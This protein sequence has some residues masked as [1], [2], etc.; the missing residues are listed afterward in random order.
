MVA[1]ST[2]AEVILGDKGDGSAA[3]R[4]A[5]KHR[6]AWANDGHVF[7][8]LEKYAAPNGNHVLYEV[9]V[10]SS[11]VTSSNLGTGTPAG[12]GGASTAMG[13]LVS[14]G[15]TEESI[16][17]TNAGCKARGHP[18]EGA[19][20]HAT[21][22]GWVARKTGVYHDGIHN[23]H[24]E[25]RLVIANPLGG[26]SASSLH[27]LKQ[28]AAMGVDTTVYGDRSGS[29][30]LGHHGAIF[31]LAIVRGEAEAFRRALDRFEQRVTAGQGA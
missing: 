2:N 19:F 9:K 28:R 1:A 16:V 24:N 15:C 4:A 17:V 30:F 25:L 11:L 27:L 31:S 5:A 23:K 21:G 13:H 14:F 10:F 6:Y 18:T 20:D 26:V 12:G 22:L 29:S 8:S 3:A 7:D